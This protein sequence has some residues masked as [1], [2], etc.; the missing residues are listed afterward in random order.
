MGRDEAP[1]I[2]R[3]GWATA[4]SAKLIALAARVGVDPSESGDAALLRLVMVLLAVGTLPLT[5]LWS[6]IYL[7]AG[8]PLAAAAPAAI[9]SSRPSTPLCSPGPVICPAET[10]EAELSQL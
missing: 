4:A 7:A 10:R 6:V 9:R 2:H 5:I 8:S 1:D 3:F